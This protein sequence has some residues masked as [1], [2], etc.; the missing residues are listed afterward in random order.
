MVQIE[1]D[2]KRWKNR[3]FYLWF[4]LKPQKG[5]KMFGYQ[6]LRVEET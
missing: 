2:H 1:T 3:P 5:K 6:T 4:K